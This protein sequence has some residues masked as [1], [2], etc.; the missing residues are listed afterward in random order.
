MNN[1]VIDTNHGK[2]LVRYQIF[3][4]VVNRKHTTPEG[5]VINQLE[6]HPCS[7]EIYLYVLIDDTITVNTLLHL[8]TRKE[9]K[10]AVYHGA[11]VYLGRG[12]S[13]C[14]EKDKFNKKMGVTAAI[15]NALKN[16]NNKLAHALVFELALVKYKL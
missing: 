12:L 14:S 16:T 9:I 6:K 5:K 3:K 4:S 1:L 8:N 2:Y 10:E 11:I 13:K 15:Y 7:C